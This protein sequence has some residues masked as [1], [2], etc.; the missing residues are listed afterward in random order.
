MPSDC[1]RRR[2]PR[3]ETDR[4]VLVI[5]G[6]HH[7]VTDISRGGLSF[8]GPDMGVGQIVIAELAHASHPAA[9]EFVVVRVRESAGGMIRAEFTST[10][11]RS[12]DMING[13]A[14][15]PAAAG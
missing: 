13:A 1:N 3:L 10:D 2:H 12:I 11:S 14:T 8:E 15:A 9:G 4:L 7:A 5:G 6:R